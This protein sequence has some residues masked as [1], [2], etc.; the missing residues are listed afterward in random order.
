MPLTFSCF[1]SPSGA[2]LKIIVR[3]SSNAEQHKTAFNQ[4]KELYEKELGIT[5]DKSGSDVSRLCYY[6][7]DR[8]IY[9]NEDAR[10]FT[11][12]HELPAQIN[13]PQQNPIK[14]AQLSADVF[15]KSVQLTENIYQFSEGNR[16]NFV[17]LLANN[18]NR[19]GINEYE[20]YSQ[21]KST[22]QLR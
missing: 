4:V 9:L 21:N 8:N 14:S 10:I 2:G 5:I 6:S 7:C 13:I 19:N 15:E 12:T 18:C 20:A 3:V 16:N 11:P 1:L 17:H 22:I